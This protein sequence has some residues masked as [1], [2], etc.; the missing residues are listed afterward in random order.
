MPS[1]NASKTCVPDINKIGNVCVEDGK[2]TFSLTDASRKSLVKTLETKKVKL[3][4]LDRKIMDQKIDIIK[5]DEKSTS[6]VPFSS[7]KMVGTFP[8]GKKK[9]IVAFSIDGPFSRTVGLSR[10]YTTVEMN[11]KDANKFSEALPK[12]VKKA[13]NV[14]E[15][16]KS[17]A[18]EM[19]KLVQKQQQPARR[20]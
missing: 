14:E 16:R 19:Q 8:E 12:E 13:R 2:F 10:P 20:Y 9:S 4:E 7:V 18:G 1:K 11:A 6:K 3:P 5:D 17:V 15:F